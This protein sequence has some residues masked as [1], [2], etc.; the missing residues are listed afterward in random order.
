V[1]RFAE[2]VSGFELSKILRFEIPGTFLEKR[3]S[4]SHMR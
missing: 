4:L 3:G 2:V 1:G